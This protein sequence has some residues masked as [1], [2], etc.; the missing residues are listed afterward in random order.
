MVAHLL[1]AVALLGED[2]LQGVQQSIEGT[3][4]VT[5]GQE[6]G[7]PL[8]ADD[9]K[10]ISVVITEDDITTYCDKT[11]EM[12]VFAYQLLPDRARQGID[13]KVLVGQDE[14]KTLHGIYEKE[15]DRLKISFFMAGK[16]GRPTSFDSD[17]E[18]GQRTFEM[19]R[20]AP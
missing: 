18:T 14:G 8:D 10:H 5:A 1:L 20:V 6:K 16:E 11:A 17:A 9:L 3:Y 13:L 15:G 2:P 12:M 19:Q 4:V 7:K